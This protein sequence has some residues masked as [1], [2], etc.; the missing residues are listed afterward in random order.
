[1]IDF[2]APHKNFLLI[3]SLLSMVALSSCT[4]LSDYEHQQ[5]KEA[6]QDSLLSATE[7][8]D[9]NMNIIE[10]G[11]KVINLTGTHAKSYT[12]DKKRETHI[13]GPVKIKVFDDS[14]GS[15][16]THVTCNRAIY[17]SEDEEF[18][19]FGDV[20]VK[21]RGGRTLRSEYL[22]WNRDKNKVSTPDFVRITTPSDSISGKGFNGTVDLTEY[23]IKKITGQ[24]TIE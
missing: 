9:I 12:V 8:W 14:T 2:L 19:L 6:L 11:N 17:R 5:V 16:K 21:N 22:K 15:V 24:V 10:S 7:S 13:A 23:K 20:Y 1:V 4:E 18:E 3:L